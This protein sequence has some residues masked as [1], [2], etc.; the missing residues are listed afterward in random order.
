MAKYALTN[1]TLSGFT[2]ASG[3]NTLKCQWTDDKVNGLRRVRFRWADVLQAVKDTNFALTGTA[4]ALALADTLAV[5]PVMK[6]ELAEWVSAVTLAADATTGT[7]VFGDTA[8]PAGWSGTGSLAIQTA[9]AVLDPKASATTG[10]F[11]IGAA[12]TNLGGVGKLYTTDDAVCLTF[13][14]ALASGL[15]ATSTPS[16]IEVVLKYTNLFPDMKALATQL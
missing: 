6:G 1:Q 13:G 15:T 8:T 7:V 3:R 10:G 2:K 11:N 14:T 12:S 5:L 9:A 4:T 16:V